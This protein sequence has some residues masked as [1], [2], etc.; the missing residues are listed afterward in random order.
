[1]Y[2]E[3]S[4]RDPRLR[5]VMFSF[6]PIGLLTDKTICQ[7]E[8]REALVVWGTQM[9]EGDGEMETGEEVTWGEEW[10]ST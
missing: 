9:E 1:M 7:V 2:P 8:I 10:Y 5:K 3:F 6:V 4:V